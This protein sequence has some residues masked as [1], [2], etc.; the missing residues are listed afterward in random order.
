MDV[1]DRASSLA[2]GFAA[3]SAQ[4]AGVKDGA[5]KVVECLVEAPAVVMDEAS[6]LVLTREEAFE[7]E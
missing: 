4:V 5:P 3:S 1:V 7:M 2:D 6:V